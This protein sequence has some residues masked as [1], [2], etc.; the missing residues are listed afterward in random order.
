MAIDL[1]KNKDSLLK[2]YND[3]VADNNSIDWYWVVHYSLLYLSEEIISHYTFPK[4]LVCRSD[5]C[6]FRFKNLV[7][8]HIIY[9]L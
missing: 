7:H 1:R 2:A 9:S 3:V 8:F 6:L 5:F 4:R